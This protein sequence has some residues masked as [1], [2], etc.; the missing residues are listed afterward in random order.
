MVKRD[1]INTKT[2]AAI[3][4]KILDTIYEIVCA[5]DTEGRFVYVNKS[6][7]RLLGYQPEELLGISCFDLIIEE[8]K[9][10]SVEA[11]IAGY[12]GADIPVFENRFYHKDGSIVT[13]LW[14]GRWDFGD[15]L[16]YTHGRDVTEQRKLEQLQLQQHAYLKAAQEQLS[17]LLERITDGFIG[18]DKDVRVIYWNKAAELISGLPAQQM[19]GQILWDVLT[20]PG[21]SLLRERHA[22]AL[23]ANGSVQFEYFSN[24]IDRWIEVTTYPSESGL[25]VFFRDITERKHL[26]EQML[27][28]REH[29]QMR[30]AGAVV[31]ATEK[32]RAEVSKEL[33]D[34]VNQVLT[35]VKLYTE[36]CLSHTPS[37]DDLLKKS[38]ELLQNSIDE[39]RS[40]SKRL[41]ATSLGKIR[42]ADSVRE[43]VDSIQNTSR[44]KVNLQ[45]NIPDLDMSDDV[46][47]T[48][49]RI[50]QE[51]FTNIIN[52]AQ[53]TVVYVRMYK[54]ENAL[55]IEITDNGVGFDLDKV[56]EGIGI[57]NMTTRAA[58]VN[59]T[60]NI[61]SEPGVGSTLTLTIPLT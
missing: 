40:L 1:E 13:I 48:A 55:L 60:I 38:M 27:R 37:T 57:A 34:N 35:T 23:R 52:H 26:Q 61:H 20:E 22:A 41:S 44:F 17:Q 16:L 33:H 25:S 50:L 43:L 14:E 18:L 49:Y 10:R 12:K 11:S 58:D 15:N 4:S 59:A 21:L 28:E 45:Q 3:Q 51:Q 31:K 2:A 56:N 32:E 30:V 47:L 9:Q 8:D 36:L 53:A 46:H 29:H 24:R 54:K 7:F 19:T 5:L 39:I 6:S 42:L